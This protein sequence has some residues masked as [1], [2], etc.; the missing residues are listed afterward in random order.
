MS[1]REF[2]PTEEV[3]RHQKSFHRGSGFFC[4]VVAADGSGFKVTLGD[5]DTTENEQLSSAEMLAELMA[6]FGVEALKRIQ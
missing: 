4:L 6:V 1:E 5:G 2:L 3:Q